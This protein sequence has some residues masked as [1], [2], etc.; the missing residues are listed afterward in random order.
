MAR[1]LRQ[2]KG[3]LW[4]GNLHDGQAVIDDLVMDLDEI[5]TEYASIKA[6]RKAASEYQTYIANNA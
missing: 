4:N 2:V 6:L 1:H 3:Y 5:E